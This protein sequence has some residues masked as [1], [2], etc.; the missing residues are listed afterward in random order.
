MTAI[1]QE[2]PDTKIIPPYATGKYSTDQGIVKFSDADINKIAK[3]QKNLLLELKESVILDSLANGYSYFSNRQQPYVYHP[4]TQTLLTIKRGA[5]DIRE[6]TEYKGDNSLDNLFVLTS[7]DWGKTWSP[8]ALVYDAVNESEANHHYARYPSVYPIIFEDELSYLY[9]APLT[10]GEGWKGFLTGIWITYPV[11]YF[12]SNENLMFEGIN[13]GW[14]TDAKIVGGVIGSDPWTLAIGGILPHGGNV[15][16]TFEYNSNLAYRV[17][18]DF[19]E[20]TNVVPEQWA[21]NKFN[22]PAVDAGDSSSNSSIIGLKK[23]PDGTLVMGAFGNFVGDTDSKFRPGV[24]YSADDGA[25]WTEFNVCPISIFENYALSNGM[26]DATNILPWS[27]TDMTAL[28][29]GDVSFI[30]W[31]HERNA[32]L[33]PNQTFEHCVEASF[34][35]D[36]WTIR[37]IGTFA[38]W[39]NG[40]YYDEALGNISSSNQLGFEM[41]ISRSVDGNTLIAKWVDLINP[42]FT[43]NPDA[44]FTYTYDTKDVFISTRAVGSNVWSDPVN[45]TNDQVRHRITWLPDMVP[46][47]MTDIPLLELQSIPNSADDDNQ[48]F[49]RSLNLLEPQ[50]V[51]ISYFDMIVS[52]DDEKSTSYF[53]VNGLS[54]NPASVYSELN[55]E[56]KFD[57][58]VK[59]EIFDI[60][61]RKIET[62]LNS[63]VSRGLHAININTASL[64]AGTYYVTVSSNEHKVTEIMNVIR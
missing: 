36:T 12:S 22:A 2:L 27:I 63:F 37:K 57:A 42:V 15:G 3:S 56:M 30:V 31:L 8:P 45:I 9:T 51:I 23:L 32:D 18:R 17:T 58:N 53:N 10:G 4:E 33:D 64:P 43:M 50:Y 40:S 19:A 28:D 35:N 52:V 60:T 61:G 34:S 11:P 49:I 6:N 46:N 41:Q 1:A 14:G 20:W 55:F 62:A 54:P 13:Y 5:I 16:G 39:V 38:S 48:A 25:T 44:T 29:N 21:T 47:T 7:G 24:S 26:N 59:I